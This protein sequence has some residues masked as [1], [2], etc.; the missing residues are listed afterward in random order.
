MLQG[1]P[2]TI[3]R[4]EPSSWIIRALVD[5]LDFIMA[6]AT[7]HALLEFRGRSTIATDDGEDQDL[8]VVFQY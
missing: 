8:R 5:P 6:K 4:M 3:L 7:G 2:V 1:Q